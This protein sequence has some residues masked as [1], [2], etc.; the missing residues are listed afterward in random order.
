MAIPIIRKTAPDFTFASTSA[1]DIYLSP[2]LLAVVT[3][4]EAWLGIREL[5][6]ASIGD[7]GYNYVT[8]VGSMLPGEAQ[9]AYSSAVAGVLGQ[10]GAVGPQAADNLLGSLNDFV[11]IYGGFD[12]VEG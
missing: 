9:A 3:P 4:D 1:G 5:H 7:R 8:D 2:S 11:D 6:F 10:L 12:G